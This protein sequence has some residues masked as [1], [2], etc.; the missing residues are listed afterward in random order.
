M[1]Q[2]VLLFFMLVAAVFVGAFLVYHL[3]LI[4]KGTTTYETF[5]RRE[6]R[7]DRALEAL[8]Q[9]HPEHDPK[10]L[11][12]WLHRKGAPKIPKLPNMYDRGL[13]ANFAEVFFPERLLN[14][15]KSKQ[16]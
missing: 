6:A 4:A 10:V 11:W 8:T 9:Q 5:K 13:R 2:V 12:A 7:E 16:S 3:W 14:D 1:S 15:R